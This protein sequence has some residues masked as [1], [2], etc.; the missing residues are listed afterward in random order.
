[1]CGIG[2][3]LGVEE[4]PH[5]AEEFAR[6]ILKALSHRGPD[7]QGTW[8]SPDAHAVLCHT[9]LAIIDLTPSGAQPML[10]ANG[11]WRIVF[12]G[13][14]YNHETL[15]EELRE[16]GHQFQSRSDTEVIPAV[17]QQWGIEG[18]ARLRGMFAFAMWCEHTGEAV[19]ARD[20]FGIK[21]LYLAHTGDGLIFA[22][23]VRAILSVLSTKPSI[24]SLAVATYFA[25]GTVAEP[26]TMLEGVRM[27]EPGR[28]L[29]WRDGSF[30]EVTFTKPLIRKDGDHPINSE[31][32]AAMLT[33]DA[34]LDSVAQHLVSD[35]PVGI[36]LSGGM[37]S[38]AIAAALN[39]LSHKNTSS[40]SITFGDHPLSEGPV[41]RRTAQHFGLNHHEWEIRG[42]EA[43]DLFEEYLAASDQPSID[44]FN[45]FCVS[46]FASQN[47]MK[48]VL[49]GLGGD[50]LLGS[51][52]SF[53]KLPLIMSLLKSACPV[54][55][56]IGRRLQ[57][58]AHPKLSRFGD[59]LSNPRSWG[60]AHRAYRGIFSWCETQKILRSYGLDCADTDWRAFTDIEPVG[61]DPC[62]IISE[63]E[64]RR[65]MRN[66]LLRDSDVMSMANG[67]ELRVPFVDVPFADALSRIAPRIR[68]QKA[69]RLLHR[70][71]SEIPDWVANAPKRG[72]LFP[73]QTW[74]GQAWVGKSPRVRLPRELRTETWYRKI[75]LL[76]FERWMELRELDFAT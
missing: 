38:T 19:L 20:R 71:M 57:N 14:I 7:G 56:A 17:Y 49:S 73:V 25:T 76:T 10:C 26:L 36:F 67:L 75:A 70:A 31:A 54:G 11:K 72:F 62:E 45:T 55:R 16:L 59:M 1:M 23:E 44:G 29:I 46:R 43:V 48:V 51:Y 30:C 32:E 61:N 28:A 58:S 18:L 52:S 66:Q 6:R 53:E 68:F 69:K 12:N 8:N 33:R 4:A 15:R 3:W 41:S 63:L 5:G 13:E 24:N 47:G 22:S 74:L 9:R 50:E 35:V 39:V 64:I 37:D 60:T 42:A 27:L 21:P 40:F 34:F 65:Y 2:G